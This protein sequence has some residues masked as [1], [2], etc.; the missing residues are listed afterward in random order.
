MLTLVVIDMIVSFAPVDLLLSLEEPMPRK[1]PALAELARGIVLLLMVACFGAR[2]LRAA[3][4]PVWPIPDWQVSTAEE[5]GMDSAELAKII[6]YGKTKSFDSLLLS[7]HGRIVLD[8]YYAPYTGD[9]PHNLN[10]ATKS[11]VS[12]LVAVPHKDGV[13]DS[14]VSVQPRSKTPA[15][16]AAGVFVRARLFISL[17]TAE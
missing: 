6:A 12:S 16:Q 4:A 15:A 9:I 8:A 1:R 3:E 14:F 5:Q 11:V 2:E 10:S 7:R 13:L 17:L